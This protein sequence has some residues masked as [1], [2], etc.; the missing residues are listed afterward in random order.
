[1]IQEDNKVLSIIEAFC[2]IFISLKAY[3]FR[4]GSNWTRLNR[5]LSGFWFKGFFLTF[6]SE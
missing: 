6:I 4:D 3:A 5:E 1:M 2:Q